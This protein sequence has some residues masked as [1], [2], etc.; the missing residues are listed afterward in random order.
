MLDGAVADYAQLTWSRKGSNLLAL[1]GDKARDKA[2]KDN[3]LLA[4]T[5]VATP[6]GMKSI[7]VDPAKAASFPAGMVIS[8]FTG[9]TLGHRRYAHP[10]GTQAAGNRGAG[11]NRAKG[12]RRR[13][14]LEG[15]GSAVGANHPCQPGSPRHV[16]RCGRSGA[17]SR[18]ARSP[19]TTCAR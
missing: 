6:A 18:F 9:A 12:Q 19:T 5:N 11:L 1:R 15:S 10:R 2:Q 8:E 16:R 7:T 4:W 13:M 14:A 3:V 17:G